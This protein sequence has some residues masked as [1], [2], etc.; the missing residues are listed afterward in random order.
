MFV[1][2][3][4]LVVEGQPFGIRG[5]QL[6]PGRFD[7]VELN[8]PF[9]RQPEKK[10]FKLFDFFANCEYFEEEFNYDEVLKLPPPKG[11]PED[12]LRALIFD[13]IYDD[14]RGV[15]VYVRVVDGEVTFGLLPDEDEPE[16]QVEALRTGHIDVG[17]VGLPLEAEGM[18]TETTGR[19]R[20]MV[21]LPA[22]HP[23]A[24][25]DA[26]ML[27]E[28]SKEAYTLW[29]R[30]LSSGSYDHLIAVFRRAGFGPPITMEGGLPSTRT[31]LG[32][33][34]A[35]LTIALVDPVL[36]QMS[37]SGVAFRPL[38][39]RGVYTETGVIYRRADASPIL[40]AMRLVKDPLEQDLLREA[41]RISADAHR[42]MAD[43]AG[44]VGDRRMKGRLRA[45]CWNTRASW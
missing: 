24:R 10:T 15:I 34:E 33:I 39:G 29:P 19:V 38:A 13:S 8:N 43:L 11:K 16:A 44:R 35:G 26:V 20:L 3:V 36:Q 1:G 7:T 30:H 37:T 32:M 40:D 4:R 41:S 42:A 28:L 14:Y 12:P 9:Y 17:F 21:A 18:V 2:I 5:A 31:I 25:S 45:R 22:K 6:V 27:E 23:M